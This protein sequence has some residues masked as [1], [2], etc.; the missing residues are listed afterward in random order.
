M[1][2]RQLLNIAIVAFL[3]ALNKVSVD[4]QPL[5]IVALKPPA[6]PLIALAA[7]VSGEVDLKITLLEDGT[8]AD[9]QIVS[10][11]AMLQQAAADSAKDSK[12]EL[13]K[14]D[15][16]ESSYLLTYEFTLE[17]SDCNEKPYSSPPIFRYDS[18][19]VTTVGRAPTTCDPATVYVRSFKCLYLWR[20]G[21][22]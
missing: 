10:G 11:P 4:A 15:P 9:I 13:D 20:C 17:S 12:F 5:K 3:L 8:P 1:K 2:P 6:Y 18:N 22:R 21:V 14:S 19:T 16:A 7:R